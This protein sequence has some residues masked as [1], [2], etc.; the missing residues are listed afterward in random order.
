MDLVVKG[1]ER[2]S[3]GFCRG[4]GSGNFLR[5]RSF[6]SCRALGCCGSQRFAC[7]MFGTPGIVEH[8]AAGCANGNQILLPFKRGRSVFELSAC[9]CFIGASCVNIFLTSALMRER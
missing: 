8:L 9:C 3:C 5:A 7:G 6:F 2:R 4:I 1:C